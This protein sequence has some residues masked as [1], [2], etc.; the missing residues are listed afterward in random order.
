MQI[1][2]AARDRYAGAVVCRGGTEGLRGDGEGV[3][4]AAQS[5]G[6][7]IHIG[8]DVTI[9]DDLHVVG[10][11]GAHAGRSGTGRIQDEVAAVELHGCR[12]D[13][14]ISAGN[15][16][17]GKHQSRRGGGGEQCCA[18]CG[19]IGRKCHGVAADGDN[20]GSAGNA[21]ASY[22]HARS[23]PRGT[24]DIDRAR[25]G[26]GGGTRQLNVGSLHL[27]R[28]G[29]PHSQIIRHGGLV[30]EEPAGAGL[31]QGHGQPAVRH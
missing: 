20:E 29:V 4:A 25:S 19:G 14:V 1:S 27:D 12:A 21:R 22:S 15:R 17:A 7:G 8:L 24:G 2:G 31:D 9:F 3:A 18:S 10:K 23:Q 5:G 26:G 28:G 13:G 11:G 30:K 6:G 16:A